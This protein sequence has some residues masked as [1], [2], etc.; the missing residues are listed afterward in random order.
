MCAVIDVLRATSTII[1][2]LVSGARGVR[3]CLD[4]S[5]A[6]T[7]AAKLNQ[8]ARLLG[9][10]EKGRRIPGFD[11][12]NSPLE[13]LDPE[14]VAGKIVFF[15][16]TNGSGAIRRAYEKCGR[17][18]HI[19]ALL[20]LTAASSAIV[21]A[22][23]E[24]QARGIVILCSGRC[25]KP[26]AEDLF[27]AGLAVEKVSNGLHEVGSAPQLGDAA[28]VALAFASVNRDHSL[29]IVATS[30]HG[31]F[32]ESIGFAAD[33]EYSSQVD[34]HEVVPTF[35]GDMVVIPPGRP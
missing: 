23:S 22:A 8:G 30:E 9:G 18:V 24:G 5:E 3:P 10:E 4:I 12:G 33:L 20:N 1:T 2:A 31:R 14:I 35:E 17:P 26:S 11:L 32:L 27:C 25:G 13:Y 7:G 34:I 19:A 6:K 16:T 29:N 15:Y 21:R 28:S